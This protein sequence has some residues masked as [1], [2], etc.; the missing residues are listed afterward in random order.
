MNRGGRE[1]RRPLPATPRVTGGYRRPNDSDGEAYEKQLVHDRFHDSPNEF[2]KALV[3]Y[4]ITEP[5]LRAH[6]MWQLT[7]LQFIDQRFRQQAPATSNG[8]STDAGQ[9]GKDFTAW[10]DDARKRER[11]E[12]KP[13]AFT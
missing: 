12:Y 11:I 3:A 10:L 4:G 13:E 7:V 5:L 2:S 8:K 6:L 9:A 1:R